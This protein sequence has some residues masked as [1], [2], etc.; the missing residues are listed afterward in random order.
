MDI[1][2]AQNVQNSIQIE[3]LKKFKSIFI[4]QHVIPIPSAY[5]QYITLFHAYPLHKVPHKPMHQHTTFSI[6]PFPWIR[7]PPI[8]AGTKIQSPLKNGI[9]PAPSFRITPPPSMQSN[10][11]KEVLSVWYSRSCRH[12]SVL[13]SIRSTWK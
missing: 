2:I 11:W 4:Q 1:I 7:I 3:N 9:S 13:N 6:F 12:C 5:S 10:T 8:P